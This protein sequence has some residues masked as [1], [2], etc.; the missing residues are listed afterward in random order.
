MIPTIDILEKQNYRDSEKISGCWGLGWEGV[1]DKQLE[2][3][4]FQGS[5]NGLYDVK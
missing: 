3:K 5:E 4:D 1:R 2:N